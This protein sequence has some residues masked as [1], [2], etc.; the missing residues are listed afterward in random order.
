MG[1]IYIIGSESMKLERKSLE[2]KSVFKAAI[3]FAVAL[4]FVMPVAAFANTGTLTPALTP[5]LSTWDI[6][7]GKDI[8]YDSDNGAYPAL[9]QIDATHY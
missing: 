4:A 5:T 7:K 2:R 9:S 8:T 1:F 6:T 3:A